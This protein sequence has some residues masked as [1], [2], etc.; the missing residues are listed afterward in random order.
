MDINTAI[1]HLTTYKTNFDDIDS[2]EM[3][4]FP[5]YIVNRLISMDIEYLDTINTL[6]IVSNLYLDTEQQYKLMQ[7]VLPRKLGYNK[8]IKSNTKSDKDIDIII[9]SIM[10]YYNCNGRIA[11]SYYNML[12][13]IQDGKDELIHIISESNLDNKEYK[14]IIKKIGTI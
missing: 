14:K 13:D 11:L 7:L 12:I 1:K 9:K 4:T 5:F 6:Q 3:A 2:H 8:L 10:N